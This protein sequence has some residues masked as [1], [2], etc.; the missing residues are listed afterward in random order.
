MTAISTRAISRST[1]APEPPL[2]QPDNRYLSLSARSPDSIQRYA[3]PVRSA[4]SAPPPLSAAGARSPSPPTSRYSG[5][6]AISPP[7]PP[8]APRSASAWPSNTASPTMPRSR[9]SSL[10]ILACAR[11]S[12]TPGVTRPFSTSKCSTRAEPRDYAGFKP[13]GA[14][15]AYFQGKEI[16]H[17]PVRSAMSTEIAT[18]P[19]EADV[20]EAEQLMREFQVHR[21]PVVTKEGKLVGVVTLNDFARKAAHDDNEELGEQVAVT[22]GAISQRRTPEALAQP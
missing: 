6:C 5:A 9:G 15:A 16:W 10:A 14:L 7:R 11:T 18:C 8:G 2:V 1:C 12:S 19:P 21:L 22:L 4:S 13:F 17:I 3:L 20:E